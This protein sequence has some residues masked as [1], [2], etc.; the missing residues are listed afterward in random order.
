MYLLGRTQM[1][2]GASYEEIIC[3]LMAKGFDGVEIG[4]YDKNFKLCPD[5]FS[6]TFPQRV[7]EILR[8][9]NAKA[10]SVGAHM[11]YVTD[12]N[13]FLAVQKTIP[14]AALIGAGAVIITGAVDDG[15]P[16]NYE[17]LYNLQVERAKQLCETAEKHGIVLAVE[18]EPGFV[19]DNTD[20]LLRFIDDVGSDALKINLDIGHVFLQ[21]DRPLEA[22]AKCGNKIVHVHI[23]NMEKDRHNHL[24]PY[25]GD[26]D[27]AAYFKQLLKAG[28]DGTASLDL[29]QYDYE[30]V[31]GKSLFFIRNILKEN[32]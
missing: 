21:D 26:M 19:I 3:R 16:D 32:G 15:N 10:W 27:L 6:D 22:I 8:K 18:F 24:V 30:S 31:A 29:Y 4:I 11:D 12:D 20:K 1:I 14:V 17:K 2:E 25:E 28:F 5:F 23:E 7:K 9:T 13:A